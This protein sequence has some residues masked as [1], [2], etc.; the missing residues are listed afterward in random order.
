[1]ETPERPGKGHPSHGSDPEGLTND[2]ALFLNLLR[3]DPHLSSKVK[4]PEQIKEGLWPENVAKKAKATKGSFQKYAKLSPEERNTFWETESPEKSEIESALNY[5]QQEWDSGLQ[6]KVAKA[7]AKSKGSEPD[8]DAIIDQE[9]NAASNAEKPKIKPPDGT[10]KTLLENVGMSDVLTDYP[11]FAKDCEGNPHIAPLLNYDL[12]Q[13][14]EQQL[15][16][17]KGHVEK[18]FDEHKAQ[19][20]EDIRKS[21]KEEDTNESLTKAKEFVESQPDELTLLQITN[22][23]A[24]SQQIDASALS[25]KLKAKLTGYQK[26]LNQTKSELENALAATENLPEAEKNL[27]HP[28]IQN[29]PSAWKAKAPGLRHK[30]LF[31]TLSPLLASGK[32]SQ[33]GYAAV[34]ASLGIAYHPQHHIKTS[35]DIKNTFEKGRG[36]K[37]KQVGTERVEEPP[38]SGNFVEKPIY[39][40][41]VIPYDAGN[42]AE[43]REGISAYPLNSN[44]TIITADLGFKK[45]QFKTAVDLDSGAATESINRAIIRA[46]YEEGGL[47]N[48]NRE[49]SLEAQ[50]A[51]IDIDDNA[52]VEKDKRLAQLTH[53]HLLG[54]PT[55]SSPE[56]LSSSEIQTLRRT[57]EWMLPNQGLPGDGGAGDNDTQRAQQYLDKNS[58]G[59]GLAFYNENGGII[60]ENW[61]KLFKYANGQEYSAARDYELAE[62]ALNPISQESGL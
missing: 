30:K 33:E 41:E 11:D 24:T 38:D 5:M 16:G 12:S 37:R 14:N 58:D 49:N 17:V 32:V 1:M 55:G 23:L 46:V 4:L 35:S 51:I 22:L 26:Q 44:E 3:N 6:A 53:I 15:A 61:V 25:E 7:E 42:Q 29:M 8:P 59:T 36:T 20:K 54:N 50:G 34:S 62:K 43:V 18:F 2:H 10:A 47:T 40:E 28:L 13:L 57:T 27:I 48:T 56:L 45:L 39:E 52:F 19:K 21:E 9:L 60:E 31:A